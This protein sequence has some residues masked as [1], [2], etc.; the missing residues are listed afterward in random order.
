[1]VLQVSKVPKATPAHKDRKV[2]RATKGIKATRENLAFK[3]Q[4]VSLAQ[5]E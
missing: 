2:T 5:V 1:M 3:G 4:L